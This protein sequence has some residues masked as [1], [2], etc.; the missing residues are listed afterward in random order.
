MLKLDHLALPVADEAASRDWYVDVLGMT[1]EFELPQAR[2]LAVCD[3]HDFALFLIGGQ[4][5]APGV[6][7]WF[8]VADV[9]ARHAE[10]AARGVAFR[11][12]PQPTFWGYGAEL[13]DPDGYPVRLWDETTMNSKSQPT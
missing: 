10:L 3:E 2:T 4:A 9:D 12:P 7:L 1:V 11:H 8:Q 6:A 5:L 13:A